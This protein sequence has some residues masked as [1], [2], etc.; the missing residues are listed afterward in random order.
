[1]TNLCCHWTANKIQISHST[2]LHLM[3]G[4]L[5]LSDSFGGRHPAGIVLN[6]SNCW[7]NSQ[8]IFL[9]WV[10]CSG[11]DVFMATMS[12]FI[13]EVDFFLFRKPRLG[14]SFMFWSWENPVLGFN[15]FRTNPGVSRISE[16]VLRSSVPP[17]RIWI[18]VLVTYY[19]GILPCSKFVDISF[20]FL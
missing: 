14:W 16:N 17:L 3:E 6:S 19:L 11:V 8:I 15:Y 2:C 5:P 20:R 1:M 7:T 9:D 10:K 18:L 4:E 12:Y 13:F